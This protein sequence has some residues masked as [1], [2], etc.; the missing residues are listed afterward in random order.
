MGIMTGARPPHSAGEL[1]Q[2]RDSIEPALDH[3]HKSQLRDDHSCQENMGGGVKPSSG[4]GVDCEGVH[5]AIGTEG[6]QVYFASS[7]RI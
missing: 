1:L 2:R 4:G 7:D 3:F 5:R 6:F